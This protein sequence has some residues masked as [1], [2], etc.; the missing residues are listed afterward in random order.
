MTRLHCVVE[1]VP[2]SRGLVVPPSAGLGTLLLLLRD[3]ADTADFFLRSLACFTPSTREP[4][5]EE[6]EEELERPT[7]C[8]S[9]L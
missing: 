7:R 6:E 1:A 4:V 2:I 8:F 3:T 5:P 9:L